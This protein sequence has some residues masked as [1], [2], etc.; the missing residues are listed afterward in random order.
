MYLSQSQ[1]SSHKMTAFLSVKWM[2]MITL[3]LMSL[4]VEVVRGDGEEANGDGDGDGDDEEE[5]ECPVCRGVV[6]KILASVDQS[7]HSDMVRY[8]NGMRHLSKMS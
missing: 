2:L 3:L 4:S 1:V 5:E 6:R 7:K 8:R